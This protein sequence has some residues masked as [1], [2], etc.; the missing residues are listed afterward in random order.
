MIND[1]NDATGKIKYYEKKTT[2]ESNLKNFELQSNQESVNDISPM[3]QVKRPLCLFG[4]SIIKQSEI[5]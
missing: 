2:V 4:Q 3:V 5:A 1:E